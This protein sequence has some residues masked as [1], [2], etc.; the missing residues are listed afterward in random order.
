MRTRIALGAVVALACMTSAPIRAQSPHSSD[1]AAFASDVAVARRALAADAGKLWGVR[2]D[3]LAWL[4]VSGSYVYL[5]ADPHRA[6]Y[7]NEGGGLWSGMLPVAISPANTATDWSGRR[8][9]MVVLPLDTNVARAARML[10]HEA[11]HVLQPSVLPHPSYSE[12]GAGSALLDGPDGR[13]WMR[14]E[15]RALAAALRTS[16]RARTRAITD[17]LAFRAARY[18]IATLDERERERALDINEG[19]PEYS[20]WAIMRSPRADLIASLDSAAARVPSLVRAFPYYTGPAYGTLLDD[21]TRGAWR[22]EVK[23]LPDLQ[24][25]TVAAIRTPVAPMVALALS[26]RVLSDSEKREVNAIAQA[27]GARYGAAAIVAEER[28]RW[29]IRS[30]QLAQYRKL[31]IEG[32]TLRVRPSQLNI[33]F[34]P[35]GQSS[36]GTEGTVMANLAWKD[37]SASLAAPKG[38]LVTPGWDE[39]RVPLGQTTPTA[40]V[41]TAPLELKGDG[42][43]LRL[44][45]GWN[46]EPSGGSWIVTPPAR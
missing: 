22:R 33:T 39:V 7:D 21:Y 1:V 17:A 35:R 43:T 36:L 23:M 31:F 38:A 30:Q 45:A 2:A 14:L 37:G 26:H 12:T 32:P 44:P 34:D 20:A 15:L 5:T 24:R 4:G 18:A 6:G 27:D 29:E 25:V 13:A 41:L 42:W 16:G 10:V 46:V 40:G 3:T 28:A 11:M 8:W 19:L 9:A